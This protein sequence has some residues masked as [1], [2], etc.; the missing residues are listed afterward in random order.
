MGEPD[1]T[2]LQSLMADIEAS[3]AS[4]DER[5]SGM[6]DAVDQPL[7]PGAQAESSYPTIDPNAQRDAV[8]S[9]AA[10]PPAERPE[11][12]HTPLLDELARA[13][14][15][16]SEHTQA[17]A[18]RRR[19]SA[20]A[21]GHALRLASDYLHQ[22][23]LHLNVLLPETPLHYAI[24]RQHPF[25]NLRWQDSST[26]IET[27]SQSERSLIERLT[28]RVRYVCDPVSVVVPEAAMPRIEREMYL[29]NLAWRDAGIAD[30]P[31]RRLG[32]VIEVDGSIPLQLAFTADVDQQ[33]IILRCRN[34]LGLGLSAYAVKPATIDAG[35]LDMLGRCLLGR[36][37]RLPDGFS[38]IA[39]NT[40]D[41]TA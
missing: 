27:R 22:L 15:R 30:I 40:P 18:E 7:R 20:F 38:P 37:K 28:L 12:E 11:S 6:V 25:A 26:R 8:P 36:S 3:V 35:A 10:P 41:S 13:A 2:K 33:R 1:E 34:F 32:H 16:Q 29:M 24:D 39:F 19:Q 9:P 5:F 14:V 4:F 23:T 21:I 31:G 17:E